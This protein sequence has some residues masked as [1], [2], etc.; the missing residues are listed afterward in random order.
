MFAASYMFKLGQVYEE[1]GQAD[2]ALD[3]YKKIEDKYPTSVEAYD[4]G[5]YITR[6][7]NSK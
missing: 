5:K 4:I 3:L 1:L 2:K 6:I 7:E